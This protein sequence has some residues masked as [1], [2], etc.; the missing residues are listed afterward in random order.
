M[1]DVS[2]GIQRLQPA[3]LTAKENCLLRGA[4]KARPLPTAVQSEGMTCAL[5]AGAGELMDVTPTAESGVGAS[6]SGPLPRLSWANSRELWL[7]M[8]A[9]DTSKAAPEQELRQL[10]PGIMPSMRTILFDW[11]MEVCECVCVTV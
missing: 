10:H 5:S 8:R 2:V 11:L 3:M 7:Q 6:S 4:V 9:K 1:Q